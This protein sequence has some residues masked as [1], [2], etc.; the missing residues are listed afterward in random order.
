MTY[1][2]VHDTAP[3]SGADLLGVDAA[4]LRKALRV[5]GKTLGLSASEV[6]DRVM[7]PALRDIAHAV[8]V[9][10]VTMLGCQ[11]DE[12]GVV[13]LL[14]DAAGVLFAPGHVR[15]EP[16]APAVVD[17]AIDVVTPWPSPG[18]YPPE[19]SFVVVAA[20]RL[21]FEVRVRHRDLDLGTLHV[22]E[23]EPPGYL[24]DY[25]PMAR[26]I[27]DMAA[28]ALNA[29]RVHR[30]EQELIA[31]LREKVRALDAFVHLASHDLQEPLRTVSAFVDLLESDAG[32]ELPAAA[33]E[34]LGFIR[35]AA[36]RMRTLVFAL[37]DLSRARHVALQVAPIAL[38]ACVAA[39]L[40]NLKAALDESGVVIKMGALPTVRGDATLLV[41]LYQNL[42]GNAVKFRGEAR[43][44]I[45]LT[46][47]RRKGHLVL[48][49]QDNGIGVDPRDSERIFEPF[50]RLYGRSRYPGSGIGLSICRTIVERHGGRLW[51]E[52]APG[53]GAHF[54]FTLGDRVF[55]Q[56]VSGNGS[57]I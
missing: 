38:D 18:R 51:V 32:D 25:E 33:L 46:A 4:T 43:P 9:D 3:R 28:L 31:C 19:R 53:G 15:F 2:R 45:R 50:E 14:L 26:L 11:P 52:P 21:S 5:A 47:V 30:R 22:S 34:D 44:V 36:L 35:S 20:D 24:D 41:Q 7:A 16:A 39:A 13:E 27:A 42:L 54:R 12:D 1:P 57:G 10:Y 49:V 23:L 48:G 40:S 8:V 56:E 17:R 6:A 37:L 29:A 55:A